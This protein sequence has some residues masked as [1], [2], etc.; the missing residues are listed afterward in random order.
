MTSFFTQYL[1]DKLEQQ[2]TNGLLRQLQ[3]LS[4]TAIDLCSNDYL[5]IVKHDLI[6]Q[7]LLATRWP[8]QHGSGASRLLGGNNH[9]I[10]EVE[11]EIAAFHQQQ[12]ALLMSSGYAANTAVLACLPQKNDV[13]IYDSLAHASLRDGIRLSFAQN[14]KFEHNNLNELE[15]IL[16]K[17]VGNKY[18][19]TESVFSMDGDVCPLQEIVE[20]KNKYGAALIIDEAHGIGVIGKKG[21]GL[22][23][24]LQLQNQVD[25]VI[26]TYGKAPGV[27]GAAICGSQLL[28][29]FI[30]NF[31]RPFIYT[32]GLP[33]AQ[34]AAI[35]A[36]YQIFPTQ[37]QERTQL[38]ELINYYQSKTKQAT[39]TPIQS[40]LVPGNEQV[41]IAAKK[42]QAQSI[43]VF[44][45]RYPTVAKGSER[46]RVILHSF[47]TKEHID[48]LC[49]S[50]AKT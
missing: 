26:Y 30:I 18:I 10:T 21:E 24:H 28:I 31:A 49:N 3:T 19:V 38:Q 41:L 9:F 14:I 27:H 34:A 17:T 5:G 39:T 25:V 29:E 6:N 35:K 42:L 2:A 20:L 50:I 7:K 45:V 32:T 8:M 13:I 12:A 48:L 1:S 4:P 36:S 44:A 46:L 16:K 43:N 22:V 15:N 37:V 11:N 33:Q 40:I 23:N 47:N